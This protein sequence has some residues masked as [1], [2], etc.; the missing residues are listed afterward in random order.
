[1]KESLN[2]FP[3]SGRALPGA[4]C[5][6]ENTSGYTWF[7]TQV[8]MSW[9]FEYGEERNGPLYYLSLNP[10]PMSSLLNFTAVP[11][12]MVFCKSSG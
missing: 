9:R 7:L 4:L 12:L 3:S 6:S 5:R 8:E 11:F 2:E 1:M 10:V